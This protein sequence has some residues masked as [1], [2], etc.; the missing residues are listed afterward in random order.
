MQTYQKTAILSSSL[1]IYLFCC[2]TKVIDA[3]SIQEYIRVPIR[4]FKKNISSSFTR[5]PFIILI[6]IVLVHIVAIPT[7]F[8]YEKNKQKSIKTFHP[9]LSMMK[10]Q[11]YF[12]LQ[13][14]QVVLQYLLH[15]QYP[16]CFLLTYILCLTFF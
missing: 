13:I 16:L 8:H 10:T 6:H 2:N 3:I 15:V 4:N 11:Q 5:Q 1:L 12:P 14:L 7:Q 9:D